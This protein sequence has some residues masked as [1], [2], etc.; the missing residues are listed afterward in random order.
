M[1]FVFSINSLELR[2][3]DV[4]LLSGS[5]VEHTTAKIIKE[6]SHG[7]YT[8]AYWE[9]GKEGFDLRFV[10]NRPFNEEIEQT[11]FWRIAEL[12]QNILDAYF[13]IGRPF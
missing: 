12:G 6:A 10:G 11:E 2:S 3:C 1:L 5:D 13:P 4:H 8:I 9:M 7:N